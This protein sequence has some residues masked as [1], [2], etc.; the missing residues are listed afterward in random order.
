MRG[1][2]LGV[3]SRVA[4]QLT[5][6]TASWLA[7]NHR[8]DDDEGQAPAHD[9]VGVR[10]R[11]QSAAD[12]RGDRRDRAEVRKQRNP[13]DGTSHELR[14]G[15]TVPHGSLELIQP[16]SD[17]VVA[18]VRAPRALPV[19]RI[20]ACRRL[21]RQPERGFGHLPLRLLAATGNPFDHP[22]VAIAGSKVHL[23]I[24]VVGGPAQRL[25]HDAHELDEGAPIDGGEETQAADR[26]ADR[27]LVG[28]L[29]LVARLHD[30]L[31]RL[32]ILRQPLLH[33]GQRHGQGRALALQPPHEL[34]HE[35]CGHRRIRTCHVCDDQDQALGI[36]V[37]GGDHRVH[38]LAREVP[39]DSP[40][41]D[42]QR[43]AA[44]VLDQGEPQHDRDR[45]ELPEIQWRDAFVGSNE[46]SQAHQVDPP[47]AMRNGL[48]RD[49]P[50][51][52][53]TRRRSIRE[54]R[55]FPAVIPR[56]VALGGADLF[57][58]QVKIVEQPVAGR[59]HAA[60]CRDRLGQLLEYPEENFLVGRQPGQ[61]LVWRRTRREH[62]RFREI[63][64]VLLHLVGAE[65]LR[66]Q[67]RLRERSVHL[68]AARARPGCDAS[69]SG[70]EAVNGRAHRGNHDC[71]WTRA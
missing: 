35:R 66:P 48:E 42:T 34:G 20:G 68:Q 16:A 50:D 43:H 46:T 61:Q 25:V 41:R 14:R 47:V 37:H 55:E 12:R 44:E 39:V 70:K 59:R 54:A 1:S 24:A 57:L 4:S 36:L 10:D 71:G 51:P 58:D 65:E 30:L 15:A 40:R 5:S 67:R 19:I 52:G 7:R 26:V 27:D 3:T 28:G 2:A 18:H 49:V 9:A 13:L 33:P 17:Q 11:P 63:P 56:Q 6:A 21:A 22:P 23:G 62:V 31:D 29:D 69:Q 60:A 38:P 64:A 53:E 32:A 45:P 8:K